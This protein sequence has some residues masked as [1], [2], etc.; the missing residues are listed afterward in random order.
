MKYVIIG[1]SAAA[2]GCIEGIRQNDPTGPIVV[3]SSEPYHT[4]SRPLISY[5]L[6]GSVTEENMTYRDADFYKKNHC[7]TLLGKKVCQIVSGTKSLILEDGDVIR[8]DKL[9]IA[10]GSTPVIPPIS[11]LEDVEKKSTFLSLDDAH[12]VKQMLEPSSRVLVLGAGLIG[13]KAAEGLHGQCASITVV[14]MADRI[15]PSI[16]DEAA[17]KLVQ[18]H[19]ETQGIR[20]LLGDS[21]CAFQKNKAFTS[22]GKEI[23]FDVLII[24]VGVRPN[25]TLAAEAGAK[26]GKGIITDC[27]M[28]TSIETI[29]AA[30]DCTESID[31]TTGQ[32]KVLA[33]LPNAYMQGETAGKNMSGSK[34]AYQHAIP[35]NAIGFFG[36][37]IITAGS[38]QGKAYVEQTENTYRKLVFRD[39]LLK[40]FILI[41]CIDRA[42]ILTSIIRDEVPVSSLDADIL[43]DTPQLIMFSKKVRTAKLGGA[44]S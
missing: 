40:G 12:K 14:D 25:T 44:Q 3:I 20:F 2:I 39:G 8:Y 29:Y 10:T 41:G 31:M 37:H 19:I 32:H 13:L 21:V 36:M 4:Y 11:G 7:V 17:S 38:Y 6:G 22:A 27:Y 5:W 35:M 24:A 28:E 34:V 1:N 43:K 30:G 23:P 26:I 33:L 42:G 15:L 9:L 16:L 18:Q